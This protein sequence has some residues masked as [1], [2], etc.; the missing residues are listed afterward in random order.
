MDLNKKSACSI[1]FFNTEFSD[2][3]AKKKLAMYLQTLNTIRM[4]LKHIHGTPCRPRPLYDRLVPTAAV[5][6]TIRHVNAVDN[7]AVAFENVH[8]F[9]GL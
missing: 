4:S 9:A 3:P 1:V 2:V 5:D 6:V 8:G 7:V